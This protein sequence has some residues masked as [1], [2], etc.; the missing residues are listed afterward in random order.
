MNDTI[1]QDYQ[2]TADKF[3][4]YFAS[5]VQHTVDSIYVMEVV[6]RIIKFF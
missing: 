1:L 2:A 5:I 6:R 3:N 4:Y